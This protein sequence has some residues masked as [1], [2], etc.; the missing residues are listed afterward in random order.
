MSSVFSY[1]AA[2]HPFWACQGSLESNGFTI[3]VL[4][5]EGFRKVA[6]LVK[7]GLLTEKE[8]LASS[9]SDLIKISMVLANAD[10]LK[11][12]DGKR[13][14]RTVAQYTELFRSA[15]APTREKI[16][17]F[18]ERVLEGRAANWVGP[19]VNLAEALELR[20][21]SDSKQQ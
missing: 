12:P 13:P 17:S 21:R 1:F 16:R 5:Q 14:E 9:R 7:S 15:P 6:G 4:D 8:A 2:K 11:G 3:A 10:L 19:P 20:A 18:V